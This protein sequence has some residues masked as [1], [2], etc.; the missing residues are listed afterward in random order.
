MKDMEAR[1]F[2]TINDVIA[3]HR[4]KPRQAQALQDFIHKDE[5]V[6]WFGISHPPKWL[7]LIFMTG[8][9]MLVGAGHISMS[10]QQGEDTI[11][12]VAIAVFILTLSTLIWYFVTGTAKPILVL[13][14]KRMVRLRPVAPY[15]PLNKT[16]YLDVYPLTETS[17][18]ELKTK[19]VR[20]TICIRSPD[21]FENVERTDHQILFSHTPN[22]HDLE[23]I[24]NETVAAIGYRAPSIFDELD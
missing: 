5:P 17:T 20:D 1:S 22:K 10:I 13:L 18:I 19:G 9:V 16:I 24:F 4:L 2:E 3:T 8:A 14:S 12:S 11:V 7:P 15:N 6:L 21:L 23:L